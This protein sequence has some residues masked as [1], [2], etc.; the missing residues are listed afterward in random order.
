MN[1]EFWRGRRVLVTGHTGFKGAWLSLWLQA[2]GAE[3]VGVSAGDARAQPNLFDLAR[4]GEGMTNV[5]ADT[6][7]AAA[8]DAALEAASPEVVIHMAAQPLVNV[9]YERPV[10]T[11]AINVMG[12]AN[13]LDAVRRSDSA[14][15]V[16]VVT[17]DKCYRLGDEPYAYRE[18]DPLGGHDPYS[19]SKA[20]AEL[21][22]AAYR[23]SFFSAE[24]GIRLGT[25]RAG[26]V[27]GG[28]DFTQ[29][30]LVP[31]LMSGALEGR[32]V[33]IRA[34][35]AVR[36]WQHVLNPLSGYLLLAERL[37]ES[38]DYAQA[39]NFG[40]EDAD[41]KPV[42]EIIERLSSAWDGEIQWHQEGSPVHEAGYLHVD[43]SKAHGRLG[44]RPP[45]DL[46]TALDQI[47]GWYRAYR[48]GADVRA[49]T[50]EEIESF[51]RAGFAG[52]AGSPSP[53][54]S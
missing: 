1:V 29:G 53:N 12:T 47:A 19:S 3:P 43:S 6:R 49:R 16:I 22:A 4:V 34:P 31:D 23:D 38:A 46:D 21:V 9:S 36:P 5:D 54:V 14:R 26:N 24:D 27:V 18:D 11:Y 35:E 10:D 25:A 45:W 41:A 15:A 13:V 44:W 2:L 42:R 20:A 28:G 51:Q 40:P 37:Y 7:D 33:P 17:S 8:V 39:W 32:S 52:T 30:R 48:E 50:L